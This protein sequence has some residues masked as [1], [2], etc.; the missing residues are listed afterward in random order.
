ML[1][2]VIASRSVL[3]N[4]L[5]VMYHVSRI[6]IK[7]SKLQIGRAISEFYRSQIF[8]GGDILMK[9]LKNFKIFEKN[10]D[11]E[12]NPEREGDE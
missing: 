3:V 7:V 12:I 4:P 2:N 10:R 1:S 9:I 5:K 8:R 11:R 6:R